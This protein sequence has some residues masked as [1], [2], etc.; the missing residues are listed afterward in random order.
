MDWARQGFYQEASKPEEQLTLAKAC[1]LIALEEEASAALLE[2]QLDIRQRLSPPLDNPALVARLGR[3][4]NSSRSVLHTALAG[5]SSLEMPP[6]Q[7]ADSQA[8]GQLNLAPLCQC[9]YS[10][11]PLKVLWQQDH[12]EHQALSPPDS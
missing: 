12:H 4:H 9:C 5:T 2:G 10:P 3:S 7:I 11:S 6:H 8:L 1:M